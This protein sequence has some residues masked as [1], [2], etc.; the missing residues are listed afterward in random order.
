MGTPPEI[1]VRALEPQCPGIGQQGFDTETDHP[2]EFRQAVA[3]G[4]VGV[5]PRR[6]VRAKIDVGHRIDDPRGCQPAGG[7]YGRRADGLLDPGARRCNPPELR[8]HRLVQALRIEP[9]RCRRQAAER[10]VKLDPERHVADLELLSDQRATDEPGIAVIDCPAGIAPVRKALR[11]DDPVVRPAGTGKDA[12]VGFRPIEGG[13]SAPG[14][15]GTGASENRRN[16]Q[17]K[18]R[19]APCEEVPKAGPGILFHIGRL[20]VS[21][22]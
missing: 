19:T 12:R 11:I 22:V 7:E 17:R 21:V 6:H 8:L 16:Q 18:N 3:K 10:A 15:C 4:I 14:V 1:Q 5:Y 13:I 20:S 9:V 2:T